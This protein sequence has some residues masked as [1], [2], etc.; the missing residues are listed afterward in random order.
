MCPHGYTN[1]VNSLITNT[2]GREEVFSIEWLVR[3]IDTT[4][5]TDSSSSV[6]KRVDCKG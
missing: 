1:T 6:K 5:E 2:L 4:F 3:N